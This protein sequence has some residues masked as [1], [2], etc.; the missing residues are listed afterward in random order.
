MTLEEIHIIMP[1][2]YA[3]KKLHDVGRK[4][5]IKQIDGTVDADD[6]F[7]LGYEAIEY[8]SDYVFSYYSEYS[9][10][11]SFYFSDDSIMEYYRLCREYSKLK[12]ISLKDNP[13]MKK[14]ED[15][16]RENLDSSCY[17]CYY[18]LKTKVNHRLAAGIVFY[19][20]CD[21]YE[22]ESLVYRMADVID[23]YRNEVCVLKDEV[24][25]LKD[26]QTAVSERKAA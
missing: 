7:A 16:V 23:F 6:F 15:T 11:S 20:S 2:L 21:F 19:F 1:A 17:Y 10:D 25:R 5:V 13:Y 14:A 22:Y 26:G 3:I 24:R 8:I 4:D 18:R 9:G 12:G